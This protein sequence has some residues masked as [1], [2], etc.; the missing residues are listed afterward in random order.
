MDLLR[1]VQ[2]FVARAILEPY[3]ERDA[4]TRRRGPG[5]QDA[6]MPRRVAQAFIT[7]ERSNPFP[8]SAQMRPRHLTILLTLDEATIPAVRVADSSSN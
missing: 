3:L 4:W 5:R 7:L 2:S 6:N 1:D 8:G